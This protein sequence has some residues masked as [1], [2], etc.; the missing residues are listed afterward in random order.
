MKSLFLIGATA[1][2]LGV[3][4]TPAQAGDCRVPRAVVCK[5]YK[6]C[7]KIVSQCRQQRMAYDRCGYRYCVWVKVVTYQDVYSDGRRVSYTRV[8]PA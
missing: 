7:T 5:P 2:I 1:L 3:L 8:L 4:Q 6:V